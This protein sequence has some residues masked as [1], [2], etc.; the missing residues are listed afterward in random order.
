MTDQQFSL[1]LDQLSRG[2]AAAG[3]P[4]GGPGGGGGYQPP[5]PGGTPG[6]YGGGMGGTVPSMQFSSPVAAGTGQGSLWPG[7]SYPSHGRFLEGINDYINGPRAPE[8]LV[9][10]YHGQNVISTDRPLPGE[11]PYPNMGPGN[12][13]PSFFRGDLASNYPGGVDIPPASIEPDYS[14]AP[15]LSPEYGGP[16]S[17]PYSGPSP[18]FNTFET[19]PA[20]DFGFGPNL[21]GDF[22]GSPDFSPSDY[23]LPNGPGEATVMSP[24]SSRVYDPNSYTPFTDFSGGE[25]QPVAQDFNFAAPPGEL[26]DPFLQGIPTDYV[27]DAGTA[28]PAAPPAY[29]G[30]STPA[31]HFFTPNVYAPPSSTPGS[32]PGQPR[33]GNMPQMTWDAGRNVYYDPKKPGLIDQLRQPT[34]W[35]GAGQ[36]FKDAYGNIVNAAGSIVAAAGRTANDF[37][38]NIMNDPRNTTPQDLA[39]AGY[40]EGQG[41]GSLFPGGV[42]GV[43]QGGSGV[44]GQGGSF[45]HGGASVGA[46]LP[47]TAP[48][49]MNPH[50]YQYPT[51]GATPVAGAFTNLG[52][53]GTMANITALSGDIYARKRLREMAQAYF[54]GGQVPTQSTRA[55]VGGPPPNSFSPNFLKTHPLSGPTFSPFL[56]STGPGSIV[57]PS[58]FG[59]APSPTRSIHFRPTATP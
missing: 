1:W 35:Q 42:T 51:H 41:T 33:F 28:P 59:V 56:P 16:G 23:F 17:Y 50:G 38:N 2:G 13:Q 11:L 44:G 36:F 21:F 6:G 37:I 5:R 26:I 52:G 15:D 29:P 12:Y 55:L 8:D 7:G 57:N 25:Y 49:E 45:F 10:G 39:N 4:S 9:P 14:T 19:P 20:T 27:S 34:N 31:P 24:P 32:A 40:R 48:S 54:S 30:A 47:G 43:G 53:M 46:T 18:F 22:P 58:A 3:T